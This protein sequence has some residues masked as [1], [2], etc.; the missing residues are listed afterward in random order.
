MDGLRQMIDIALF[1]MDNREIPLFRF[2]DDPG[3]FRRMAEI[4]AVRSGQGEMEG[5]AHERQLRELGKHLRGNFRFPEDLTIGC[6]DDAAIVAGKIIV[7]D[8]VM[9]ELRHQHAMVA[10]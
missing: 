4:R 1:N 10:A 9:L 8:S 5:L 7:A 6:A 2:A 3:T